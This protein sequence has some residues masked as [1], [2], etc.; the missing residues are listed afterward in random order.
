MT[1]S[2]LTP[3]QRAKVRSAAEAVGEAMD[4]ATEGFDEAERVAVTAEVL[5]DLAFGLGAGDEEEGE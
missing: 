3:E 5:A 1:H 4:R 2:T